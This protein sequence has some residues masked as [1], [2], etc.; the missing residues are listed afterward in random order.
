MIFGTFVM[1]SILS[2][3]ILVFPKS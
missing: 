3:V 1:Y 2:H